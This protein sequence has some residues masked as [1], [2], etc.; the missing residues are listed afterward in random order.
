MTTKS[1]FVRTALPALAFGALT[2]LGGCG[3]ATQTSAPTLPIFGDVIPLTAFDVDLII[4]R[5]IAATNRN[6]VHVAVVDRTGGILGVYSTA[7]SA[8]QDEDNIAIALAR[9]TAYFS[10]SQAPLSSRTVETLSTFHFPPTFGAPFLAPTNWPNSVPL[11]NALNFLPPRRTTTGIAGTPQGPLW[12]INSTNRGADI[13]TGATNPATLFN[14]SARAAPFPFGEPLFSPSLNF[15]GSAPSPGIVLL[16]GAVPLF[17]ANSF[18]VPRLVGGVG[19]YVGVNAF[20]NPDVELAEFLAIEGASGREARDGQSD[21]FANVRAEGE[22]TI[23]GILLPYVKQTTRPAGA[24]A[25]FLPG[26]FGADPNYLFL[27]LAGGQIDPFNYLIGPR[28]AASGANQAPANGANSL[29]QLDVERIINQVVTSSNRTRAQVRLPLGSGAKVIATVVDTRG[30]ILAH[31]RMEDTLCDAVD[32]VP[33]KA[34]SVV[35]YCLPSTLSTSA[36]A[37]NDVWPGF[38]TNDPRGIALTTRTLGFLSQPFYPPG[39]DSLTPGPLYPLALANQLPT[40]IDR[41]GNA[42]PDPGYQNGLTF[43]PGSVPLYKNGQLVGA[44]GVS[45]DGVEQNDLIAFDG[46]AGFEPPPELRIDNFTFNGVR[47]PYLK[48]PET[49]R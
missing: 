44:L 28:A 22:I 40:Q 18:G 9:T 25:G 38:P 14:D 30:L 11:S 10:N 3:G 23:V 41:W 7:S 46:G 13:E 5:A 12:Q 2:L 19:V 26:N 1:Y 16:P 29:T 37:N 6:D 31:F 49:P 4:A 45:G 35:Y 34:R 24:A 27:Q 36:F 21:F 39:I 33:A 17:K 8:A 32:V 15:D 42:A 20:V 47:L 48:F 43:F